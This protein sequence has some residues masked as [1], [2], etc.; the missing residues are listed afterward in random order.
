MAS[1]WDDEN[2]GKCSNN[3]TVTPSDFFLGGSIFYHTQK[4]DSAHFCLLLLLSVI[5]KLKKISQ[6]SCKEC[7]LFMMVEHLKQL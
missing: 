6:A 4:H 7:S 2:P 1:V 5:S 3:C